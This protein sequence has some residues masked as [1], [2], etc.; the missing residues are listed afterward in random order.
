[1][2]HGLMQGENRRAGH[3]LRFQRPDGRIALGKPPSQPSMM[4]LSATLLSRLARGVLKRGSSANS[5]MFIA[6]II[7]FH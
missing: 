3:T 6:L 1:M 7:W 4:C 2:G 5:G